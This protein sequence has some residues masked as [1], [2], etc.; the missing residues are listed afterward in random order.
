MKTIEIDISKTLSKKGLNETFQLND[1]KKGDKIKLVSNENEFVQKAMILMFIA[2]FIVVFFKKK[3]NS[4]DKTEALINGIFDKYDSEEDLEK[5][6]EA[7]L[8]ID[9]KFETRQ[10]TYDAIDELFGK[11][12][13][14]DVDLKQ[15][16]QKSWVRSK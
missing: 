3:Q 7:E 13:N 1:L 12:K 8:G 10:K 6:I 15:I 5:E 2:L 16:R 14:V 9:F 4:T 11:W